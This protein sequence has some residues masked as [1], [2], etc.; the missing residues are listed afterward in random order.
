MG[1]G[2]SR[3]SDEDLERFCTFC[4]SPSSV[5]ES[6]V[7]LTTFL[8]VLPMNLDRPLR[9]LSIR[10]LK[11]TC[12]GWNLLQ[13]FPDIKLVKGNRSLHD[14]LLPV[15]VDEVNLRCGLTGALRGHVTEVHE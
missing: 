7:N 8:L 15:V 13:H 1:F 10:Q 4:T 12:R 9:L 11:E 5:K 3:Q 14:E 6:T 2:A